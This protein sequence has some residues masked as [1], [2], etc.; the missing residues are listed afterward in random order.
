MNSLLLL[1]LLPALYV[2][3][4]L[5]TLFVRTFTTFTLLQTTRRFEFLQSP[6]YKYVGSDIPREL[7]GDYPDVALVFEKNDSIR[8]PLDDNDIWN[9]LWPDQ[10]GLVRLG[11]KGRPLGI[12]LY[13]QLHCLSSIRYA[14]MIARLGLVPG[15]PRFDT[16]VIH[17]THCFHF[18]RQSILCHADLTLIPTDA[19]KNST[20][21]SEE[22]HRCR[23]WTKVREFVEKNQ[24]EWRGIPL[25]HAWEEIDAN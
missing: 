18:I 7:P 24:A 21:A 12:S 1:R 20:I 11:P 9:S 23:D 19:D 8:Y 6:T 13:H 14:Y 10:L 25:T 3:A 16:A 15:D 2:V 22:V 17:N 5:L 4:L